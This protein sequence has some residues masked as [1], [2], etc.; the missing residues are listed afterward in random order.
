[1]F[2]ATKQKKHPI[3]R[4]ISG[5]MMAVFVNMMASHASAEQIIQF[6]PSENI[7]HA[8]KKFLEEMTNAADNPSITINVNQLD[9]RLRLRHCVNKLHTSLPAGS[10]SDGR[11]TVAVSC[12]LP[13]SWKVLISA[14]VYKFADVI[15]AKNNIAKKSII[16]EQDIE[17]KRVNISTLRKE[18][19]QNK[20]QV[21]DTSPKRFLKA[22]SVIF[23]DSIC[24]VCRG[25]IVQI[26]AKNQFFAIN[27]QGIALADATMGESTK[28]RN[29][30]SKR[31]FS[32]RVIGKDQLE[33]ILAAAR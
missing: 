27:L 32:A 18:P 9:Q 29:T 17:V 16:S 30:Q 22:G 2:F 19:V 10:K 14:T 13:V 25:D 15:V 4:L 23:K 3:L 1:M 31:S 7:R 33:V 28:V 24:M 11:M 21:V 20:A 26:S 8:A 6:E 5:P 12:N